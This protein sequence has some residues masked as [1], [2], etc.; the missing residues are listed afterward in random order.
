[1]PLKEL[2]KDCREM[3]VSTSGLSGVRLSEAEHRKEPTRRLRCLGG[4]SRSK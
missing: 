3:E 2:Q 1:M 4:R